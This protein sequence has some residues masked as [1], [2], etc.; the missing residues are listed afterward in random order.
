MTATRQLL[1]R[2]HLMQGRGHQLLSLLWSLLQHQP[3]QLPRH[4]LRLLWSLLL[5]QL[6]RRL[7]RM[8]LPALW[9]LALSRLAVAAYCID[10]RSWKPPDACGTGC[11]CC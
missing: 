11:C 1:P 9:P 2:Q 5:H 10:T 3:S 4:Q 7:H 6:L 8:V